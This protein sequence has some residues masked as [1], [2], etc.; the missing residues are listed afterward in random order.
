MKEKVDTPGRHFAA[1]ILPKFLFLIMIVMTCSLFSSCQ[2][3]QKEDPYIGLQLWS[4]RD[5]MNADPS[6]TLKEVADMGYSF[7]EAAGYRDGLFYGMEPEAFKALVESHGLDFLASHATKHINPDESFEEHMLWWEKCIDAHKRAGAQY[8]IQASLGP[9]AYEN[10]EGLQQYIDYFEAVGAKCNEK[11]IRFGFHNHAN[12][13]SMVDGHVM[14]DYMLQNTTPENVFFQLD[15]YWIIVAGADPVDYFN[16]YPGRFLLLH[17]KDYAEL[18]ASGEID[19]EYI[20]ANSGESGTKYLVVEVEEYNYSPLESVRR[21][22]DYLL[23]I[24]NL[25]N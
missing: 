22:L 11:G 15:L 1:H 25:I 24:S 21:S 8:I 17:V 20:F 16:K 3:G 6:A 19:F 7:I 13:F 10:L 4:V 2:G 14:Y 18:G 5:A 23:T 9:V 12:E